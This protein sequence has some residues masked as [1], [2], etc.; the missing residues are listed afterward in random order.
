MIVLPFTSSFLSLRYDDISSRLP[1]QAMVRT[2]RATVGGFFLAGR[3]MIWWPVS[4]YSRVG[5]LPLLVT[6][7]LLMRV[8]TLVTCEERGRFFLLLFFYLP[9]TT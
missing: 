9:H 3:S 4:F 1:L 8:I 7:R 2:N 6:A 5:K